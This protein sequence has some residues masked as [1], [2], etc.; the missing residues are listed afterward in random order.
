[1]NRSDLDLITVKAINTDR[2]VDFLDRALSSITPSFRQFCSRALKN[3]LYFQNVQFAHNVPQVGSQLEENISQDEWVQANFYQAILTMKHALLSELN[4]VPVVRSSSTRGSIAGLLATRQAIEVIL[5]EVEFDRILNEELWNLL[6]FGLSTRFT[7]PS[8]GERIQPELCLSCEVPLVQQSCPVCRETY[9]EIED[10]RIATLV[11]PPTQTFF[12]PE[13]AS[14]ISEISVFGWTSILDR[15]AAIRRLSIFSIDDE[16]SRCAIDAELGLGDDNRP[17]T[18]SWS[19]PRIKEIIQIVRR[20]SRGMCSLGTPPQTSP[21]PSNTPRELSIPISHI[22]I[23]QG[24]LADIDSHLVLHFIGEKFLAATTHSID[25]HVSVFRHRIIPGRFLPDSEESVRDQQDAI[26]N[27]LTIS[28]ISAMTRSFSI[29]SVDARR[30]DPNTIPRF[31]NSLVV[32]VDSPVPEVPVRNL[33]DV[34]PG[35]PITPD[36]P[37]LRD[38]FISN[39]QILGQTFPVLFG[40]LPPGVEAYKAIEVLRTQSLRAM[41]PFLQSWYAS[42]FRWIRQAISIARKAWRRVRPSLV[43]GFVFFVDPQ[44]IDENVALYLQPSHI[45]PAGEQDRR[46]LIIQGL[47]ASLI[48]LSN[49][50][51]RLKV[52]SELGL[53]E[54]ESE[55]SQEM[56]VQKNEINTMIQTEEFVPVNPID[57]HQLHYFVVRG[58]L[59]S[60]YGRMLKEKN[61]ELHMKIESHG[62]IHMYMAAAQYEL[63]AAEMAKVGI[64]RWMETEAVDTEELVRRLKEQLEAAASVEKAARQS[65]APVYQEIL[66]AMSQPPPGPQ[67]PQPQEPPRRSRSKQQPTARPPMTP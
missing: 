16:T 64:L 59:R 1:M 37:A 48:D 19:L 2:L 29:I 49:P 44:T 5:R 15:A 54:F 13:S 43:D 50:T 47:A 9:P 23:R 8:A 52:L 25:D 3:Q 61:P 38:T 6:V 33:V 20:V 39:M 17:P 30:V 45:T 31:P 41:R 57:N 12:F 46:T 21:Q 35:V 53:E 34:V 22:F 7:Y 42:H 62:K 14:D 10:Q 56:D 36:V 27:L 40:Q 26:N 4:P 67:P 28:Y 55:L 58:F 65:I 18:A 24:S 63:A 11:I 66:A 32:E 51:N 60:P